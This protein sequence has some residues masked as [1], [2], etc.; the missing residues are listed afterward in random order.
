M[1][2]DSD[3][4]HLGGQLVTRRLTLHV[5]NSHRKFVVSSVSRCRDFTWGV[6]FYNVSRDPDHVPFRDDLSSAG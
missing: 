1:S 4:A 6:Q 3:H 5:A 2:H